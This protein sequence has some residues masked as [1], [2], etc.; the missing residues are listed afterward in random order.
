MPRAWM[1]TQAIA[2]ES[3]RFFIGCKGGSTR[4]KDEWLAILAMKSIM[5]RDVTA[6]RNVA[7]FKVAIQHYVSTYR[8]M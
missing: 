4:G 3:H 2:N 6:L 5:P 1:V 8:R 7:A